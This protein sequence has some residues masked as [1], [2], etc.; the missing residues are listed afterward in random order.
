M[1][2]FTFDVHWAELMSRGSYNRYWQTVANV[3]FVASSRHTF[4]TGAAAAAA[5]IQKP[6]KPQSNDWLKRNCPT[7]FDETSDAHDGW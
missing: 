2:I 4:Q 5:P 7:D 6:G 3:C 1:A